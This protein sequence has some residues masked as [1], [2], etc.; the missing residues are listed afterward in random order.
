M[1]SAGTEAGRLP[2][3]DQTR[4]SRALDLRPPHE[5]VELG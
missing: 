1:A 3:A 4:S 2:T 5:P